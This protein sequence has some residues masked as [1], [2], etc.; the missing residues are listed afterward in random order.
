MRPRVTTRCRA[1]M[2][3]DGW[4]GWDVFT[5]PLDGTILPGVT[6]ASCLELLSDPAFVATVRSSSE[7]KTESSE[8]GTESKIVRKAMA[9]HP[10]ERPFTIQELAEWVAT[11]KFREI[12]CVGTAVLVCAIHKIGFEG[13]DLDV[14]PADAHG[15][16]HGLG[17]VGRALRAWL[18][19]I[20]NGTLDYNG[21]GV[22]CT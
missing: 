2:N 8:A 11:H 19:S 6:R 5:P 1:R 20:Q 21:W 18:V 16:E 22:V 9:L 10:A 17:A 13:R 15:D 4:P 14:R 7:T 3:V 12:F